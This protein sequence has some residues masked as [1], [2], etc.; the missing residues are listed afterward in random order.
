MFN[1]NQKQTC[2]LLKKPCIETKCKFWIQVRGT[3]PQ[4]GNEIDTW[5][6]SFIFLPMLLIENAKE[7]RQGAAAIESFRNVVYETLSKLVTS[8]SNKKPVN[9]IEGR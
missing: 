2:P 7:T 9:L 8:L 4:T 5:D 1:T 6:C 3:H